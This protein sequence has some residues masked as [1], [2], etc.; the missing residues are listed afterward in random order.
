MKWGVINK[1]GDEVIPFNFDGSFGGTFFYNQ[2]RFVS[3]ISP[4]SLGNVFGF[5]NS[6]GS[7]IL[8]PPYQW[9][10]NFSDGLACIVENDL[11]GFVDTDFEVKITPQ[12][13]IVSGFYQGFA[14]FKSSENENYGYINMKGNIVIPANY[15]KADVFNGDLAWVMF[16]DS[17]NGYLNKNGNT[18]WR[19]TNVL[20]KSQNNLMNG[21]GFELPIE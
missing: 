11:A 8:E 20:S 6:S 18:V 7:M 17:T 2:F 10:N 3:G 19:S 1:S 9:T 13:W 12:F 16:P 21:K 5:I 4:I 15:L 14:W